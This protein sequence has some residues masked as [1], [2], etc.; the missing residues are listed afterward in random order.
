MG[1]AYLINKSLIKIAIFIKNLLVESFMHF[2]SMKISNKIIYL[3]YTFLE[4]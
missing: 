3:P 2:L 1:K 4:N